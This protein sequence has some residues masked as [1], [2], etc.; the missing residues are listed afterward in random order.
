MLIVQLVIVVIKSHYAAHERMLGVCIL[1]FIIAVKWH[2]NRL[3]YEV[4]RVNNSVRMELLEVFKA[5]DSVYFLHWLL[6]RNKVRVS[7]TILNSV[8][9]FFTRVTPHIFKHHRIHF[10]LLIQ[11]YGII[12]LIIFALVLGELTTCLLLAPLAAT[13]PH[14]A[15]ELR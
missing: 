6:R 12:L 13:P 14:F 9:H 8:T 5:P 7:G 10:Y 15:T 4:S 1:R 3:L 11:V 2:H